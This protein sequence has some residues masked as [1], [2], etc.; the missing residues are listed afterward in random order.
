[1]DQSEFIRILLEKKKINKEILDLALNIKDSPSCHYILK[2]IEGSDAIRKILNPKKFG[3]IEIAGG[4]LKEKCIRNHKNDLV[5]RYGIK[6]VEELVEVSK[7]KFTYDEILKEKDYES[8]YII[9]IDLGTT[10]C[11]VAFVENEKA[12]A[13]LMSDGT[14]LIPSTVSINKKTKKFDVGKKAE[15]QKIK[16]PKETFYSIK[17]F[18]GRRSSELKA[19]FLKQYPFNYNTKN[20]KINLYSEVLEKEFS[21]EEICAQLL[22]KIKSEAEKYLNSKINKCI[23]TVPAYFDN[24]Q[25][26]AT[27]T[28]AK[29]ANLEVIRIINEPTAAALAYSIG[30]KDTNSNTL[31]FDLGGGTFD[32]SFVSSRGDD[33]D[34]FSVIASKGDRELGGDDYTNLF[35]NFI[36]DAIKKKNSNVIFDYQ[37]NAKILEEIV[38]VKHTLSHEE[39]EEFFIDFL[40]VKKDNETSNFTFE[41]EVTRTEFAEITYSLNSKI[42]SISKS[43]LN[44]DSI[45]NEKID[46][47][48]LVGGASRM[49]CFQEL[50]KEITS[51]RPYIDLNPDEIVALG[52]A[53]CAVYDDKKVIIDVNPLSLGVGCINDKYSVVIPANTLLPTVKSQEYTTTVDMQESVVFPIYQGERPIASKNIELG[54]VHLKNILIA[55]EGEPRF[56]VKFQMNVEGIL[57]ITAIDLDTKAEQKVEIENT[58]DIDPLEIDKLRQIAFDFA[59]Q[60][61]QIIQK[62][63]NLIILETWMKIY[64]RI[65]NTNLDNADMI[66]INNAKDCLKNKEK[67]IHDPMSLSKSLQRIIQEQEV[68]KNK[69]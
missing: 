52:A 30:K 4:D 44:L 27:K 57:T 68:S 66:I 53:Y 36:V 41:Y 5:K 65:E 58:L 1:M 22:I 11:V 60:D 20:G 46:K 69:N 42:K 10:N 38:R 39:S 2:A 32:I 19:S 13:I 40:S 14:R 45:K 59:E 56:D 16:N 55:K 6:F 50:I 51:L 49:P 31:V 62:I 18:I 25:R 21:C 33:L 3:E 29:I 23:I 63:E 61:N 35:F 67:S 26:K 28:A 24:N 34:S 17:R 7:Y 64:E 43:F 12:E 37:T 15:N 48:I 8:K 9:G 47:V 54:S